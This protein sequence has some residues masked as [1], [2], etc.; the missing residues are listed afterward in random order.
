LEGVARNEYSVPEALVDSLVSILFHEL[1]FYSGMLSTF[2]APSIFHIVARFLTSRAAKT[3]EE[4]MRCVDWMKHMDGFPLS[5]NSKHE[6]FPLII[7]PLRRMK[8][9]LHRQSKVP[10]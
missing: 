8:T 7:L 9:L 4:E 6:E 5:I 1:G 3:R 2:T 10:R